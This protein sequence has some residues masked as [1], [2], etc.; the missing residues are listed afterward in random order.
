MESNDIKLIHLASY[1]KPDVREYISQDW[2]LNGQKNSFPQYVIDRKI[3]S[4]T[5]GAILE[6]F[7]ELMFGKGIAL[8]GDLEVYDDLAEIFP[9]SEQRKALDDYLTFG[10]YF[11]ELI[12]GRAVEGVGRRL[13]KINHLP[14]EKMGRHK[15][16]SNGVIKGAYYC[17]DWSN[18][19]KY[20]PKF[21]HEFQGNLTHSRMVLSVVPKQQ[22]QD[23]Y[24][25]PKYIAGL[26]YAE[27]EEEIANY[28]INHIKNGLS[29]GYIINFNN[30]SQL[31]DE[32]KDEIEIMIKKKL[33]GSNNAGK[34]ILS[35][36]DSKEVEVTV[37]PLEVNDAHSQWEFL[38]KE[39]RQ[40][41]ITAHGAYP[42]LF[43]INNGN[44]FSNN[45]DEL[46]VQSKLVQDYQIYP[47]QDYFLD[48]LKPLL[49]INGLE[50]D[51]W[52]IP[53]RDSYKS[54]EST[55]EVV[56]DDTVEESEEEIELSSDV[57]VDLESL[58]QKGESINYEEWELL[59]DR[60]CEQVTLTEQNL[61]TV[62]E[63]ASAPKSDNRKTSEQDTSL[64][65]V[66]YRYAGLSSPTNSRSFCQ[67]VISANKV[68]RA[69]DLE[70]AGAVN[71][72]FGIDGA[73]TYNIF[74]YK[75]GPNCKHW[76]QRVIFLKK[77]NKKIS[78]N[79]ARR[80]ILA[81]EPED[82]AEARWEQN[83]K[84]VAKMPIDMPNNG[85]YRPR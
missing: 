77:G 60:R 36:N 14:V 24:A 57:Q 51:L 52:F 10:Y 4:P 81:L 83:P 65:K 45:A 34:F 75:G 54:T 59:D 41:I 21:I 63:F 76:W 22:G 23:Y 5:N 47:K 13:A 79:E 39:A 53:L 62:F 31:S 40:Q 64:F 9:K 11:L 26:H 20:T 82:R 67:R 56:V 7:C 61:N 80:M 73:P 70:N 37:V 55:N 17:Y 12:R 18:T 44:G 69:E 58:I 16:D 6:V 74:K 72:G 29:F 85:Y 49:E 48:V 27:L 68:Y 50:T 25:L 28:C 33:T 38:T 2:V 15:M 46:D 78:V 30:G 71:P 84:E 1:V 66:R 43:G 42:N 8:N 32:Q 19:N 35:F 3:G